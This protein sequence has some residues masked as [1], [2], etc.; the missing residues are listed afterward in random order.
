MALFL[1]PSRLSSLCCCSDADR[2]APRPYIAHTPAF[3]HRPINC[4]KPLIRGSRTSVQLVVRRLSASRVHLP[5]DQRGVSDATRA[6][7]IFSKGRFGARAAQFAR[8]HL[9]R[10]TTSVMCPATLTHSKNRACCRRRR[11]PP[12]ENARFPISTPTYQG[13]GARKPRIASRG[14]T[15]SRSEARAARSPARTRAAF[16]FCYAAVAAADEGV[17]HRLSSRGAEKE[18]CR[19]TASVITSRSRTVARLTRS[20]CARPA[21]T[22]RRRHLP[23]RA[24]PLPPARAAAVHH[25]ARA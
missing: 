20:S 9:P 2:D 4:P 13:C 23:A 8:A 18:I 3:S 7:L 19:T 21:C 1:C 5:D 15:A 6:L 14:G 24:T 12:R 11:A 17:F 10:P 25:R 16:T 22:V